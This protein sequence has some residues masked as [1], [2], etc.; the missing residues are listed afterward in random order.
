MRGSSI[1]SL[2]ASGTYSVGAAAVAGMEGAFSLLL[3]DQNQDFLDPGTFEMEL[4]A[5]FMS[6][7]S[8]S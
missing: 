4:S 8:D 2:G 5:S 7:M 3:H 6:V 1:S